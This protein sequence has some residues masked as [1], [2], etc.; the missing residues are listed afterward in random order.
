MNIRKLVRLSAVSAAAS[1]LGEVEL[2][3]QTWQTVLDYQL[4]PGGNADGPSLVADGYGSDSQGISHWLVRRPDSSGFWQTIDDYQL[5]AGHRA[6]A[7]S[8]AS[9]AAGNL[10][11]SG[12]ATDSNLQHWI[13]RKY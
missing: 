1:I 4:T 11:V 10:L 7:A 12:N 3:A 13:V 2:N 8:V 9:D 6:D 5:A